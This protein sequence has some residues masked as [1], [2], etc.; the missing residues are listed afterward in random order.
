M[1]PTECSM[2]LYV[3]ELEWHTNIT[4]WLHYVNVLNIVQLGLNA[5]TGKP[6]ICHAP[7]ILFL[8]QYITKNH[9]GRL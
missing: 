5:C 3:L 9:C 1:T 7:A 6:N 8:E 4:Y 2:M